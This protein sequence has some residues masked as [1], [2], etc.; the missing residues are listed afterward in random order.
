MAVVGAQEK[1]GSVLTSWRALATCAWLG[2]SAPG[3]AALP[4][5]EAM[6]WADG[7]PLLSVGGAVDASAWTH[8][9][10]SQTD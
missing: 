8:N 7:L 2:A 6:R 5:T 10:S 3:V 4:C 1:G 9:D